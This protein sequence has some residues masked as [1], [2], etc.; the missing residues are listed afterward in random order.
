[1]T[2]S[3]KFRRKLSSNK[4]TK[5]QSD[6]WNNSKHWSCAFD[7]LLDLTIRWLGHLGAIEMLSSVLF[8]IQYFSKPGDTSFVWV[9]PRFV[10]SCLVLFC[11]GFWYILIFLWLWMYISISHFAHAWYSSRTLC[12]PITSSVASSN[13]HIWEW[14]IL[15]HTRQSKTRQDVARRHVASVRQDSKGVPGF[16][17]YFIYL[18]KMFNAIYA[19]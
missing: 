3:W 8:I 5:L 2:S 19:L 16:E 12:K 13:K 17:K 14:F 11:L 15:G 10:L 6:S 1:M 4:S 9:V 18:A 7:I